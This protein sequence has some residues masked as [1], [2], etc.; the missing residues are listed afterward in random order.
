[1]KTRYTLIISIIITSF[2]LADTGG[3]YEGVPDIKQSESPPIFAIP[4]AKKP[5]DFYLKN[6][7]ELKFNEKLHEPE[8]YNWKPI[9]GYH[10]SFRLLGHVR[11]HQILEL[12]YVNKNRIDL[13]LD[14]ADILVILAKG[15][16]NQPDS[17]LCSVIYYT[18]GGVTYN[19]TTKYLP[20][21]DKHAAVVI[22]RH[23]SG[24]G[25]DREY[26]GIRGTE[27]FKFERFNPYPPLKKPAK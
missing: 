26:I 23:Y 11:G 9:K 25:G 14:Q 1:M 10:A 6:I 4:S 2:S 16:D 18:S 8:S 15:Q 21:A 22:T 5:L 20:E 17:K 27:N 13:G 19:H 3:P 12:R 24:N 7:P